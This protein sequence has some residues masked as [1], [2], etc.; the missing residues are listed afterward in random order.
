MCV[1]VCVCVCVMDYPRLSEEMTHLLGHI[2]KRFTDHDQS[3]KIRNDEENYISKFN[4]ISV[5]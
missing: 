4:L 5:P 2:K 1:C 3:L